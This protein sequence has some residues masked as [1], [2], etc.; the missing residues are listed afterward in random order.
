MET[1]KVHVVG[2]GIAGLS[3]AYFLRRH[4]FD[5]QLLEA[6]SRVGGLI[7]TQ[8][9]KYGLAESGAHAFLNSPFLEQ[10]CVE[11]GVKMEGASRLSRRHRFIETCGT[12]TRWPLGVLETLRLVLGVLVHKFFPPKSF[13]SVRA[14]GSRVFGTSATT[15]LIGKVLQGVYAADVGSLSARLVFG[16]L[17]RKLSFSRKPRV[18]GSVS[19]VLGMQ[20]FIDKLRERFLQ[21]G[22]T[23]IQNSPIDEAKVRTWVERG[24]RVVLAVPVWKVS[25]LLRS[26]FPSLAA[27]FAAVPSLPIEATTV[28]WDAQRTPALRPGFGVLLEREDAQDPM[29]GVLEN[30]RIF[31]GR[32]WGE[33]VLSETWIS[34]GASDPLASA[35][36]RREELLGEGAS[37][38]LDSH[39]SAW[40]QGLPLFG[41][42]LELALR[43]H[44]STKLAAKGIFLVGNYLGEIGVTKIVERSYGLAQRL[45]AHEMK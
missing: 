8:K 29:L 31:A 39:T 4:G 32:V 16:R 20:D 15:K 17:Y 21:L 37:A 28:F 9:T 5:V 25:P 22:G 23:L 44:H 19:P 26:L 41:T 6:S 34:S 10:L 12:V 24:E 33:G 11:L 18:R 1:V 30:D 38:P 42:E 13:E 35:V 7:G 45:A 40:P 27:T 2:A 3:A 36:R 14:W 43:E